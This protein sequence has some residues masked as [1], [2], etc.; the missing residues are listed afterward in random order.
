[1]SFFWNAGVAMIQ[2]P[3]DIEMEKDMVFFF[4][5]YEQTRPGHTVGPSTRNYYLLHLV[6]RGTG[7]VWTKNSEHFLGSGSG[8]LIYP[9]VITRYSSDR[10]E[11]WEYSWIAL[12][13]RGVEK[14]LEETSLSIDKNVFR[15]HNFDFFK[16]FSIQHRNAISYSVQEVMLLKSSLYSFL[17]QLIA[18]NPAEPEKEKKSRE[19]LYVKAVVD[20]INTNFHN[21][22]TVEQIAEH[23]GL[24]MSYLGKL[25]KDEKGITIK[26]YLTSVRIQRA[27]ELLR[28]TEYTVADIAR[29]VGYQDQLQFS[30]I[31]K[32]YRSVSP[33]RFR[34]ENK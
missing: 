3:L 27:C 29:S 2:L 15:H 19:N 11:P 24:N 23:I 5:G 30:K 8:F 17:S 14:I 9:D 12:K 28:N 31:F 16:Y 13:G 32:K 6:H 4:C 22:M 25:F 21:K 34:N 20:I 7:S 1:M 26:N 18:L 10:K 33:A